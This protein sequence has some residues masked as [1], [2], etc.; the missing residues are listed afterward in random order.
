MNIKFF[1]IL[2][3]SQVLFIQ[4]YEYCVKDVIFLLQY[5]KERSDSICSTSSVGQV[6]SHQ[7][8]LSQVLVSQKLCFNIFILF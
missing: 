7:K 6:V 8:Q 3:E 5:K 4:K 2:D 1:V